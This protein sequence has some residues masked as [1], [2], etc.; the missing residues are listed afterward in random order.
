MDTPIS[1]SWEGVTN[2]G[3]VNEIQEIKIYEKRRQREQR[4]TK[5]RG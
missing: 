2:R 5:A 1:G 3:V 4:G